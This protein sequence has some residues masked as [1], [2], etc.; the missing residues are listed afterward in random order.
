MTPQMIVQNV[1]TRAERP[2]LLQDAYGFFFAALKSAH[3]AYRFR[4][5]IKVKPVTS[6]SRNSTTGIAT[7]QMPT[8]VREIIKI[9]TKNSSG[10]ELTSNFINSANDL[11]LVNYYGFAYPQTYIVSGR[12]INI[13]GLDATATTIDIRCLAWPT[14]VYDS[15]TSSYSS[16]SWLM[17]E[18]PQLVEAW[19]ATL[20][21][22]RA[23]DKEVVAQAESDVLIYSN[24]VS[25][26]YSGETF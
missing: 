22:R 6:I 15:L 21:G 9:T 3:G 23:K 14:F 19:L 25:Q 16:D 12:D 5:D 2:D 7:I 13:K 10:T 4:R 26:I 17:V 18:F 20:I 1:L 24:Q 8:E 11:N